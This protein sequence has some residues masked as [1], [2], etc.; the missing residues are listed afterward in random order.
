LTAAEHRLRIAEQVHDRQRRG[1]GE[2][3]DRGG[4]IDGAA[5]QRPQR[6]DGGMGML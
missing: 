1:G 3:I 6:E 5:L 4:E 2:I